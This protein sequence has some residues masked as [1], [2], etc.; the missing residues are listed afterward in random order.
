MCLAHV[1]IA[2]TDNDD[3]DD[4][5][6]SFQLLQGAESGADLDL[7]GAVDP[8]T[9]LTDGKRK[10]DF[11]LVYEEKTGSGGGLTAAEEV[12]GIIDLDAEPVK[13]R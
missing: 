1:T 10:I 4:I 8:T 11:V 6:L 7:V 5:V 13:G 9:Y 3:D 2:N 12:E